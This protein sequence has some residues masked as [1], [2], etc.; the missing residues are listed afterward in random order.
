MSSVE[1]IE[2]LSVGNLSSVV[3]SKELSV[4][5]LSVSCVE[6]LKGLSVEN[7]IV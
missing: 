1:D 3:V 2:V 6:K 5:T 4:E 7:S